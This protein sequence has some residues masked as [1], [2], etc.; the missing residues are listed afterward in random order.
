M[1]HKSRYCEEFLCSYSRSQRGPKQYWLQWVL[2]YGQKNT[3]A[4][5]KISSFI[6]YRRKEVIQVWND[7][8]VSY[9]LSPLSASLTSSL[10]LHFSTHYQIELKPKGMLKFPH[11]H[12]H[13]EVS[14]AAATLKWLDLTNSVCVCVLKKAKREHGNLQM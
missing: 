5:F 7:M 10:L 13:S 12:M 9:H 14:K 6:F 4:F 3:D 8:W 1:N 11:A 2:M